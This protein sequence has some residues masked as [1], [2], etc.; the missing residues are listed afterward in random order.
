M[1]MIKI[2]AIP[3]S[4][5]K[6][7]FSKKLAYSL[8]SLAPENV[9]ITVFELNDIPLYNQDVENEGFPESVLALRS[10]IESADGVIF[11]TP[12]YNGA[13]SGV[14]K[15]AIDWASRKGALGKK[16]V[17]PISG[18]PGS[19]GATKAQ[20]SLRLV[21]EHLGMYILSRPQVAIPRLPTV[22]GESGIEDEKTAQFITGWLETFRDWIVQLNK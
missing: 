1:D 21:L 22:F 6:E 12:E 16:P 18:S 3:G 17:A 4:L 19:L 7:S 15:N 11:V 10:A 8:Q 20:Q 13:M 2:V 14:I 9:E 5:R